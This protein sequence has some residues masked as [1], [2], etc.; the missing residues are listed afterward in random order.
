MATSMGL[1]STALD[2]LS[3]NVL[4]GGVTGSKQCVEEEALKNAKLLDSVERQVALESMWEND[5]KNVRKMIR[6]LRF[7]TMLRV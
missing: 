1:V 4:I 5:M 2:R 7:N 3:S 6:N